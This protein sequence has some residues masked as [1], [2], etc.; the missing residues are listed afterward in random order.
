[1]L[2]VMLAV[3]LGCFLFLFQLFVNLTSGGG[4]ELFSDNSSSSLTLEVPSG[5]SL[6]AILA[7]ATCIVVGAGG[8]VLF[9]RWLQQRPGQPRWVIA[10]AAVPAAAI[11]GLGVYLFVSGALLGTLPYGGV[12]YGG[13]QI[14]ASGMN[15]WILTLLVTIVLSV[16]LTGVSR[17][18]FSVLPLVLCLAAILA[19]VLVGSSAIRGL[20]LFNNP[21]PSEPSAA[22]AEEVNALRQQSPAALVTEALAAA[23]PKLTAA[24]VEGLMKLGVPEAAASLASTLSDADPELVATAVEALA[25]LGDAEAA[26]A[27]TDA[28]SDVDP[29]VLASV[30]EAYVDSVD[31]EDVTTLAEA[32][33]DI[34]P[35]VAAGT[36][37]PE[38]W[39]RWRSR[40]TRRP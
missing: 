13:H 14:E 35:E 17:P 22:Y 39:R 33:S 16:M 18:R 5:V 23:D 1:M 10:C 31:S 28:L 26:T 6:I 27:L 34:D 4:N 38:P 20:N 11:V 19:L 15:P 21:S 25:E 30:A 32:L 9:R 37:E 36:M 40:A 29:E 7:A 2:L 24:A 3:A 8:M 12:P